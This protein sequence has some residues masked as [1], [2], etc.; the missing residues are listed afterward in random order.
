VLNLAERIGI[1]AS[2]EAVNV[3]ALKKSDE[4]FMTNAVI[5]IMPVVTVADEKGKI[6]PIGNSKPGEITGRLMKT[7][8]EMVKREMMT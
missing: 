8:R 6:Y 1:K 7:Y 4:M 2:E 5:E 3:D